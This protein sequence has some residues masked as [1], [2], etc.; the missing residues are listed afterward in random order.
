MKNTEKTPLRTLRIIIRSILM[1]TDGLFAC[2]FCALWIIT[3]L[4]SLVWTP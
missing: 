1:R 4:V 3:A 2:L